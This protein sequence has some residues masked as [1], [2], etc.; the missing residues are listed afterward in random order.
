M[1]NILR[2][3]VTG[4]WA[5]RCVSWLAASAILTACSVLIALA[6]P[7]VP[8]ALAVVLPAGAALAWLTFAVFTP[9]LI[10]DTGA[11]APVTPVPTAAPRVWTVLVVFV[12]ALVGA[13]AAQAIAGIALAVLVAARGGDVRELPSLLTT[14]VALVLLG[15]LGQLA[16]AAAALLAARFSPE[17]AACRLG[18]RRPALSAWAY[19]V[20]LAASLLPLVVGVELSQALA[21]VLPPNP[22]GQQTY[23]KLTWAG[24]LL[25][26]TFVTLV[27][28]RGRGV[29]VSRIYPATVAPAVVPLGRHPGDLTPLRGG[30]PRPALDRGRL[31]PRPLAG[32]GS[33]ADG[34]R[35]AGGLLPCLRQLLVDRVAGQRAVRRLAIGDVGHI[36]GRAGGCRRWLAG[37]RHPGGR[38]AEPVPA[39]GDGRELG[40]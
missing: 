24:G 22:A 6:L 7:V 5:E 15:L 37:P 4:A 1:T 9:K 14:P 25:S 19:P 2:L 13:V 17:S 11:A 23:E 28:P 12:T 21:T 33:V 8:L 18:L 39:A 40:S 32:V 20:L 34:L 10:G 26:L 38:R 31:P 16:F 35:L 29:L 3:R 27:P 36:H 30:T